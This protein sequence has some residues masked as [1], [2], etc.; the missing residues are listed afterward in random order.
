MEF[1]CEE[2]GEWRIALFDSQPIFVG[3]DP[4]LNAAMAMK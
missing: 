3:N 2:D 1:R 4:F